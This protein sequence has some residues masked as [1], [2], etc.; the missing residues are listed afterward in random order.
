MTRDGRNT[1]IES[2]AHQEG[3]R[4]RDPATTRA[5]AGS[6]TGDS[7]KGDTDEGAVAQS[8]GR[9]IV[10]DT[11]HAPQTIYEIHA[12]DDTLVALHIRIQSPGQKKRFVWQQPDGSSGLHDWSVSELPLYGTE[13]LPGLE[14]GRL[15]VVTE[16]EKAAGALRVLGIP[17]V[18][19]VTGAAGCPSDDV[20]ATLDG[21]DVA[22]W[23]DADTQ[24]RKHA[25]KLLDGLLRTRKGKAEG[26]FAVDPAALGL[27]AKGADADDWRPKDPIDDLFVTLKPYAPPPVLEPSAPT[28]TTQ[29]IVIK[30]GKTRAGLLAALDHLAIDLRYDERSAR[31][32]FRDATADF[33]KWTNSDDMC[34]RNSGS[35][36][37]TSSC[38]SRRTARPLWPSAKIDSPMSS[39]PYS[40]A[41]ASTPSRRGSTPCRSGTGEAVGLLAHSLLSDRDISPGLLRWASFSVLMGAVARTYT[42]GEKHDEMVILVGPQGLGKSTVWAWLLPPADRRSGSRM[43]SSSIQTSKPSRGAPR[44]GPGRG[45]RDERVDARRGRVD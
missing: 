23:P 43:R 15:V 24:G 27:T 14:S 45:S 1:L 30:G 28:T 21:F 26:L 25:A 42:P 40:T 8:V 19:T 18:G 9:S 39:T 10:A 4:S 35:E 31:M 16:G 29:R 7:P 13:Q 44:P 22:V 17:A 11:A 2:L 34:R 5:V 37:P 36:S 12:L 20:L 6:G 32:Q 38:M 41:G 33:P 3:V